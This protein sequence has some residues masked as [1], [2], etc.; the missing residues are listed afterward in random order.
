MA[1]GQLTEA[2]FNQNLNTKFSLTFDEKTVELKLVEIKPYGNE[3][4]SSM[5][6]FSI[7]LDGPAQPRLPQ[8]T[9]QMDH[10]RMGK[11][12][13]FIV[14]ISGDEKVIRYEAVFNC[15]K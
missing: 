4:D 9:Y 6:R 11:V 3:P 8:Q 15:F 12:D 10:E 7:Y 1:D 13:I 5:E 2:S 14:P